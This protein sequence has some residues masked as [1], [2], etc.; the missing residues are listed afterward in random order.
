MGVPA[1]NIQNS[2]RIASN[3]IFLYIRMIFILGV[4]LYTSRVVLDKL[5][6]DDYGIYHA[7][8]GVV[9]MLSFLN[10]TLGTG[11]SRFLTFDL[12][13]GDAAK[14]KQTF[15]TAFF[16]HLILALIVVAVLETAG[17]WFVGNK[18]VIPPERMQAAKWVYQISILTTFVSITQ[19][20][21][22]SAI[23]AHE[24]MKVYAYVGVF[25]AVAKLAIVY[26]LSISPIDRLVFYA[27]L[28]AVVQLLVA[29]GYRVYCVRNYEE[30]R[31]GGS[32]DRTTLKD[33][34]SFSGLGLIANV[35]YI[36]STQGLVVLINMFFQP[37]VVAAQAVGNQISAAMMQF[38]NNFKTAINPQI[39]KLYAAGDQA[40]SR[41]LTLESSVYVHELVLLLALPLIVVMDPLLHLWLVEVPPYTVVF[42]QCIVLKQIFDVYNSTLYTPM[43]ASG[44]LKTNS[45]A[46][47]WLGIGAFALL[48][49]L[50]KLGFDVMWVQYISILQ[51]M[52]FSYIVKPC[53]LCKEI[54]YSWR[55]IL[56]SF[57]KSLRV[58]VFPVAVSICCACLVDIESFW[59]MVWVVLAICASVAGSAYMFLDHT[60]RN[61]LNTLIKSKLN[62]KP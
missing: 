35:S 39:I 54:G 30:A 56:T 9:A 18:L 41:R 11:T 32:F 42:A 27:V 6:V 13:K 5:G 37:A 50:L 58:S 52:L 46:A 53:I 45:W 3:T 23:I 25:E 8:A 22:T 43:I 49:I 34:L 47:V 36:L 15:S 29:F 61:K 60:T 62:I 40:A 2:R 38:V 44:K 4:S 28:V 19:V 10:S 33:M 24:N 31:L 21:Y 57:W 7:V 12:G 14:L 20:P 17:L 1:G 26:L 55:E 51:V 59:S 16:T 48:Y